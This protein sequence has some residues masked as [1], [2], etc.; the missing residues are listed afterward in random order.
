MLLLGFDL[1]NTVPIQDMA[2]HDDVYTYR[3]GPEYLEENGTSD[4][5]VILILRDPRAVITSHHPSHPAPYTFGFKDWYVNYRRCAALQNKV[6]LCHVDY[7]T[8]I[9]RPD[10]VQMNLSKCMD[11]PIALPF[12]K[13]ASA[14][15]KK[16]L[17]RCGDMDAEMGGARMLEPD[18]IFSWQQDVHRERLKDQLRDHPEIPEVLVELGFEEDSSWIDKFCLR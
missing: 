15:P 14:P 17:R 1:T 6:N 9:T 18:K 16:G 7:A 13:C 10:D 12:Y 3:V 8:L 5:N 4:C 11:L 2:S